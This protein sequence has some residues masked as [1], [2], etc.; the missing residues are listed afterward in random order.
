M[1]W[2]IA[3]LGVVVMGTL[4]WVETKEDPTLDRL[5]E[6]SE[7]VTNKVVL[8]LFTSEGCSSCPAADRLLSRLGNDGAYRYRVVPLAY[9]VDYWD[10]I[11]WKDPFANKAFTR[12]Q[13]KYAEAFQLSSLYTPQVVIQGKAECVGSNESRI[14]DEIRKRQS[15]SSGASVVLSRNGADVDVTVVP[16]SA[17]GRCNVMAAIF[18]NDL[19][20]AVRRGENAGR[21]LRHD[22]V[23]RR[24]ERLG[25]VEDQSPITFRL[26]IRP[27]NEWVEDHLGVAVF[28]QDAETLEIRAAESLEF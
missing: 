23:V 8:E 15:E 2:K 11:G 13:N 9:H 25:T 6:P 21:E 14:L 3:A 5:P 19:V 24:L 16:S 20:T 26:S 28:L 27:E 12:R 10:Y 22:F 17:L 18:E 4:V 1:F 7:E